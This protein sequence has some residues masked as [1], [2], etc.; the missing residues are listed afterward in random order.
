MG[1]I[2]SGYYPEASGN[3]MSYGQ[4]YG[5]SSYG[6]NNGLATTGGHAMNY[7][8]GNGFPNGGP[9]YEQGWNQSSGQSYGQNNGQSY[10][11]GNNQSYS[12]G[13]NQ[14]YSQ[15][16]SLKQTP[17]IPTLKLNDGNE[18]PILAF[19]LGSAF[20]G[21]QSDMV[22]NSAL[23]AIRNGFY[24]LDAAEVYGNE[25][26]LGAAIRQSGVPRSQLYIT[27]KVW[28]VASNVKAAFD[29][30]LERL[31]VDY[32]DLY[33]INWP[34]IADKP[35]RL[36]QIWSEMEA[37]K[38]SGRARSIGVSN[39]LQNHLEMILQ[40]ARIPPAVNQIEYH[41]Y[42]QHGGLVDFH[43]QHNIVTAAYSPLAPIT[44]AHPGPCDNTLASLARKYG[45]GEA[46]I[47]IRWVLDQGIV[48]VTTSTSEERVQ[49][50]RRN[51][52]TFKLTEAE[53]QDIGHQGKQKHFRGYFNDIY[54]AD[55]R[56]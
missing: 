36:Q 52:P 55:D 16:N 41:T 29:A 30:S 8:R 15:V 54:G 25:K 34:Q 40:T 26:E 20:H 48:A 6:Q 27:T 35:D 4:S 42:L 22:R 38:Q 31:G 2:E 9:N 13:N 3:T 47:A 43:R 49:S 24:H 1:S 7:D 51:L 45:V 5:Q 18:I 37:I 50:L 10:S 12:Q 17:T 33:L 53:I 46:D 23:T 56:R 28:T 21:G 19:G 39:F 14:S 44:K 32:V 11:Q